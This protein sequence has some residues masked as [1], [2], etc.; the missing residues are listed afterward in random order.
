MLQKIITAECRKDVIVWLG[1]VASFFLMG[2]PA[3]AQPPRFFTFPAGLQATDYA[4]DVVVV[5]LQGTAPAPQARTLSATSA[6]PLHSIRQCVTP[7]DIRPIRSVAAQTAAR[8]QPSPSVLDN[9]YMVRLAPGES[10]LAAINRLLQLEEVVYAE[11][12]YLMKPLK[13]QKVL[14][15]EYVPSDP[16]AAVGKKQ[17]YLRTI[18]AHEAWA[19]EKAMPAS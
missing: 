6:A 19:I 9:I 1:W 10:L 16:E 2:I 3:L 4:P 17:N 13:D 11:P 15:D 18:R 12:Y 14:A 5:K 7:T 8:R